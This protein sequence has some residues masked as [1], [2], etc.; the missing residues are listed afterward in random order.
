MSNLQLY[1]E[2][3]DKI[4]AYYLKDGVLSVKE[5]EIA[6]RWELSFALLCEHRNKKVVVS[7][8][9]KV[10][11]AN[12]KKLSV[13]QAYR[14]LTASERIFTPLKKYSNEF[15]RLVLIESA[16]RDVKEAERR[17]R[18]ATTT[19]EWVSLMDIKN[20]A[21]YRIVQVSG[22]TESSALIPDFSKLNMEDFTIN[23]PDD[24]KQMFMK[25]A[26]SGRIDATEIMKATAEDANFEEVD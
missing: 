11:E 16:I 10:A 18:K 14:D 13:A 20:K 26:T 25:V 23:I 15:L 19:K 4:E 12:G 5:K 9:I 2:L 17:S 21:E 3:F 7:K 22:L 24:L 6:E 1:T 8:L